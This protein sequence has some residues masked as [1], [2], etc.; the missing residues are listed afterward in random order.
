[1]SSLL[2]LP[3]AVSRCGCTALFPTDM[4]AS[5]RVAA[6]VPGTQRPKAPAGQRPKAREGSLRARAWRESRD[7]LRCADTR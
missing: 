1:M 2:L 4:G 3:L 5:G 6:A 7:S